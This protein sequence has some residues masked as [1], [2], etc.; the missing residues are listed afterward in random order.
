MYTPYC[1]WTRDEAVDERANLLSCYFYM[2]TFVGLFSHYYL[3]LSLDET[4]AFVASSDR[5]LLARD[6]LPHSTHSQ[7]IS[8]ALFALPMTRERRESIKKPYAMSKLQATPQAGD[9]PWFDAQS[10]KSYP[11]D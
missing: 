5:V 2:Y 9:S 1:L 10:I 4:T 3:Y 11:D 8:Q 6:P 7:S